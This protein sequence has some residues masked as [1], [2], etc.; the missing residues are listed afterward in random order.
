MNGQSGEPLPMQ[1]YLKTNLNADL[2]FSSQLPDIF[3]TKYKAILFRQADEP[4][5]E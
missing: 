1:T 3:S 4:V 5:V 2:R